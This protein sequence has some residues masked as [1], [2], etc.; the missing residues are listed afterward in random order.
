MAITDGS[1]AA[2]PRQ[3]IKVAEVNPQQTSGKIESSLL[4]A[5][6]ENGTADFI[7]RFNQQA[8]LSA[9]YTMDWNQ[10]GEF[11]YDTLRETAASS[12]LNA[13][14]IL[15]ATGL[16]YQTFIAGND[17][18][19]WGGTQTAVNGLSALPEVYYI[20]ATRTYTIDP[21]VE[22]KPFENITWA[23][24]LLAMH[25]LTT[26]GSFPNAILDWG[27]TDTKANQFWATYGLKG[28]GMVVANIDTGVQW[29][30][31]AL[32]NQ[33][34]CPGEPGNSACW[35]DPSIYVREVQL[36]TIMGTAPTP[37]VRW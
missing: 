15:D 26:V 1:L 37:W 6:A 28:D 32:I 27:I 14:A 23:G 9:A 10:R 2:S 3:I 12:Q 25:S 36:A 20:R 35:R 34:K 21:I 22:I 5:I 4:S 24:D 18:Y 30:H 16:K 17:L 11:V 29:N 13:K 19:V 8:D 31:P 33:F 7:V